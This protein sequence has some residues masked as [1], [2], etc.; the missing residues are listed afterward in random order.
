MSGWGLS[1]FAVTA[2]WPVR[3]AWYAALPSVRAAT[4]GLVSA[5]G[6]C[7]ESAG[8]GANGVVE[9]VGVLDDERAVQ[10][11]EEG[12][13]PVEL[14]GADSD[15]D[16]RAG[17]SGLRVDLMHGRDRRRE[18]RADLG[19]CALDSDRYLVPIWRVGQCGQQMSGWLESGGRS[20]CSGLCAHCGDAVQPELA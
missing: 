11:D 1:R 7:G 8:Q 20:E 10:A 6:G 3:S 16:P 18:Q 5:V 17:V 15:P 13:N 14:F 19:D 2:R 4:Y 9:C 12:G